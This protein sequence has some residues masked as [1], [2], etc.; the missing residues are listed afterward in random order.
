MFRGCAAA[1]L[2][3]LAAGRTKLGRNGLSRPV[4]KTRNEQDLQDYP[5]LTGSDQNL[6]LVNPAKILLILSIR[7]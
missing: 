3:D 6:D 7:V 4:S 2:T 5:G 1:R